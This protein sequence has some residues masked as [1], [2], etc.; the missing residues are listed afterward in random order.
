MHFHPTLFSHAVTAAP[1]DIRRKARFCEAFEQIALNCL[2]QI[3]VNAAGVQAGN[4][5]SLHQMRIGVRRLRALLAGLRAWDVMPEGTENKLRWLGLE[6][7][8][9]R[10]WDVF[11]ATTLPGFG[12]GSAPVE[13]K[14]RELAAQQHAHLR[15]ILHGPRFHA[16]AEEL[17]LWSGERLWRDPARIQPWDKDTR[18]VAQALMRQARERVSKRVRGLDAERP[19]S[20]HRLRIAVKKERY[21]R[22]FFGARARVQLLSEAQDRLG[23][24]NDGRVARDLLRTLQDHLPAHAAELSFMEGLLAG[25]QEQALPEA[26][27]FAR[28]KL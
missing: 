8:R 27:R 28:R 3:R 22:E 10:N 9:A 2:S 6:L 26:I 1:V 4:P 12:G 25:R 23:R 20:L 11:I 13:A 14:A 24:L 17:T 5:E 21:L 15:Q 16:L 19:A 18:K 7:G